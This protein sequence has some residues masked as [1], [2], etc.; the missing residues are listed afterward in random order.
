[1]Y[2]V[3]AGF[4]I[5]VGAWTAMTGAR[6]GVIWFKMCPAVMAIASTLLITASFS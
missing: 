3:S 2:R 6:T 4:L 5:A 1:V